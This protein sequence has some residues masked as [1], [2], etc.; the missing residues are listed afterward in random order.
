MICAHISWFKVIL[1]CSIVPD[2]NNISNLSAASWTMRISSAAR[3][4]RKRMIWSA[5][6]ESTLIRRATAQ[7][8]AT[9]ALAGDRSWRR[10]DS[11]KPSR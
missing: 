11:P 5:T 7:S 6:S 8:T 1:A 3:R 4:H 2:R 9:A 10:E